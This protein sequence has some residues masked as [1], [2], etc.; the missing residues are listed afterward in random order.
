[1]DSS[2]VRAGSLFPA[3]IDRQAERALARLDAGTTLAIR[4]DRARIE[5]ITETTQTGMVAIGQMAGLE[6]ALCGTT[7]HAAGRI[8]AAAVAGA[9]QI[10]GVIHSTGSGV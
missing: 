10:V 7:P 6:A 8:Q 2:L 5:R 3:R 1:M 4:H 9:V